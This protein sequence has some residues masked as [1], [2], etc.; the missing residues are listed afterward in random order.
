MFLRK[1]VVFTA[2]S[3]LV[4]AAVSTADRFFITRSVCAF[5]SPSATLFVAGSRAI[6]PAAKTNP[7][8]LMACEYGPA[9]GGASFVDTASLEAGVATSSVAGTSNAS[10]F[11]TAIPLCA[12]T[13]HFLRP[14]GRRAF[15]LGRQ[16]RRRAREVRRGRLDLA[17]L[18]GGGQTRHAAGCCRLGSSAPRDLGPQAK[19]FR[20]ESRQ[21]LASVSNKVMVSIGCA[22]QLD[23]RASTAALAGLDEAAPGFVVASLN[24]RPPRSR[25]GCIATG[26][27]R[28][29]FVLTQ[30]LHLVVTTTAAQ[31]SKRVA[32][33][34]S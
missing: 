32:R 24:P 30:A 8:A 9:A 7:P 15:P 22:A 14:K 26:F 10:M 20:E 33:S 3:M 21:V 13:S 18:P 34:R 31:R 11:F 6:W 12:G 29:Q 2:R 16:L 25:C 23:I 5:T 19:H 28:P 17:A 4:P 1:T 27:H